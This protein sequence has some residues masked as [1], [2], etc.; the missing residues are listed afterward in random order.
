MV[1]VS[2]LMHRCAPTVAPVTLQAI[3]RTESG[4]NPLALDVNGRMRLRSAPKT[5][6]EA[7]VWSR[8]LISRGYSVD[9][10]L[11]QINSHN[12]ASLNLT[13]ESV[14]EPCR[15]IHAGAAILLEQFGVVRKW[16]A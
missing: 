5:A 13:P 14:F 8:W 16:C 7:A 15:N 1:D 2:S 11:M 4:F 3:I 9:M 10:A 12:L 6:A